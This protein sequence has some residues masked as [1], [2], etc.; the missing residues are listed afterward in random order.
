MARRNNW[1]RPGAVGLTFRSA[2]G[3]ARGELRRLLPPADGL[4]LCPAMTCGANGVYQLGF[5]ADVKG[6]SR[7]VVVAMAL[8][9]RL[10][11]E[12]IAEDY[13]PGLDEIRRAEWKKDVTTLVAMI[14]THPHLSAPAASAL[15]RIRSEWS[16]RAVR[17]LLDV[18]EDG[19]VRGDVARAL[20]QHGDPSVELLL[21][22]YD[23]DEEEG[24][25]WVARQALEDLRRR[26]PL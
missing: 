23:S 11:G 2:V 19:A 9:H 16:E 22:A 24:M 4:T 3:I 14:R 6:E 8:V 13:R 21:R 1:N 5:E 26:A 18:S 7:P 15:V 10:T 20:G 17:Q 12:A 25:T